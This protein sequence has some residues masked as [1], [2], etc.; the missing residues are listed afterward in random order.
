MWEEWFLYTETHN[1]NLLT[2]KDKG[3]NLTGFLQRNKIKISSF[4]VY[5]LECIKKK[6]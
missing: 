3:E 6:K 4:S 5:I 2:C 1:E